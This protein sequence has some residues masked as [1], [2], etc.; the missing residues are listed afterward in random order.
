[1]R[2]LMSTINLSLGAVRLLMCNLATQQSYVTALSSLAL[3]LS[4]THGGKVNA[5]E[6]TSE[7]VKSLKASVQSGVDLRGFF[8]AVTHEQPC[9][10]RPKIRVLQS[11]LNKEAIVGPF[12]G[13]EETLTVDISVCLNFLTRSETLILVCGMFA[14]G[15]GGAV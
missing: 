10:R 3:F 13:N 2:T 11:Q 15:D 4:H 5:M 9:E 7:R 8:I 12:R 1:M 6:S 14:V